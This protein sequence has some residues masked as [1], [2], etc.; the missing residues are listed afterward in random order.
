[1][2]IEDLMTEHDVR[3]SCTSGYIHYDREAYQ[4]MRK[5]QGA[6][7]H[8]VAAPA[9]LRDALAVLVRLIKQDET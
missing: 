6:G 3:I 5:I 1:M 7:M 9:E 8:C 4:V 2:T